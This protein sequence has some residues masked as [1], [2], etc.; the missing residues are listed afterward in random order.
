[1]IYS[2]QTRTV[3]GDGVVIRYELIRKNIARMYLRVKTDGRIVVT[4]NRHFTLKEADAFVL[5]NVPY[6]AGRL[7]TIQ[8]REGASRLVPPDLTGNGR[9]V[10]LGREKRIMVK[11]VKGAGRKVTV[12]FQTDDEMVIVTAD[13]A[14]SANPEKLEKA[15]EKA[16]LIYTKKVLE[17]VVMRIYPIFREYGVAYPELHLRSMKSCWGV[18]HYKK[19][20]ITLNTKLIHSPVEAIEEVVLHEF[21]HFLVPDHS[22]RFYE[23]L[24]RHMPDYKIRKKMLISI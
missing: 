22:K 2:Q 1:M 9:T 12:D 17:E 23:I 21:T 4:A 6:I 8:N 10:I 19:G 24:E 11:P 3:E 13:E 14:V 20:Y 5:Q 15:Y 16:L 7:K 18:C